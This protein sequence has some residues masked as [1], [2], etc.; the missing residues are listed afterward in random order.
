MQLIEWLGAMLGIAGA[1]IISMNRPW[2]GAA[3]PIWIASNVSL[4]AF[5]AEIGAWGIVVMQ[6]AF[7]VININ[8]VWHW[9]VRPRRVATRR[10]QR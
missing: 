3:W 10:E 1:L 6:A 4:I 5:A 7:I 9:W 2:S 8:G